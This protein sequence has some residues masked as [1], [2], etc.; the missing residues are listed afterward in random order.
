MELITTNN[1]NQ[2]SKGVIVIDSVAW[3]NEYPDSRKWMIWGS[4]SQKTTI[5]W[6]HIRVLTI[7]SQVPTCGKRE[8]HA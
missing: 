6:T 5:R 4:C 1:L 7:K 8:G 3:R 2:I